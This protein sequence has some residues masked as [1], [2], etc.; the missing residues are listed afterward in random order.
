MTKFDH[1]LRKNFSLAWPLA[2][3]ALLIQSMLMIDTLLVA[4]LGETSVAAMG[5]AATLIT[6]V[7]GVEIAIGN[8]VQLLIGRAFGAGNQQDINVAYWIGL[9]VNGV[10]GLVFFMALDRFGHSLVGIITSD[11]RLAEITLSYLAVAKY[12]VLVNAYSQTS[13]A[14]FNGLGNAKLPLKGFVLELPI[15]IAISYCLIQGV[16]GVPGMGLDGAAWGSLLAVSVRAGF[17]FFCLRRQ[18]VNIKYPTGQ[19]FFRELK[20]QFSV[21]HPI[22]ANFILLSIGATVYQLLFAQLSVYAFAAITLIFPWVRAGTQFPNA[23]AQASAITISQAL[24]NNNKL[25]VLQFI[26]ACVR[27][28]MG[29]AFVTALL[30]VLLSFCVG[31]IY[32]D[33]EPETKAA[34]WAIAPLYIVLPIVRAYNTLAGNM[35]RALGESA[36]V[37][38]IHF[39]TQWVISVPLCALLILYLQAS[40]FWAFAVLPIEEFLKTIPFYRYSMRCRKTLANQP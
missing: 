33:I 31:A 4:P 19:T 17:L 11:Q 5:I 30:F 6:F 14:L 36:R 34:L 20:P 15:N 21:I 24:G 37:L 12:I 2:F 23:W 32:P 16:A 38:K 22:A 8:G 18:A 10:T 9:F 13:T 3:N 28:G 1:Y 39:Y 25:A 7:L 35:L 26:P 40:I 29:V 27:L